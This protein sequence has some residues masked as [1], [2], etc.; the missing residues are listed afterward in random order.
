MQSSFV[1]RV[2]NK[3]RTVFYTGVT[4]DLRKR[5]AEHHN[6]N[7]SKFTSKYQITD[8]IYFEEF[9]EIKQAIAREKQIKNWKKEWKL[10]LIKSLNPKFE[11]LEY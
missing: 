10:D 5:V 2:T 3:Y 11:T 9:S 1:Y 7:G 6:G 4:N 8:L